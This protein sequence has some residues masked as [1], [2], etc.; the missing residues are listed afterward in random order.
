MKILMVCLGNICRSPI[1]EG[2]LRQI[3][4]DADLPLSV[5]S[6]G[7]ERYH[8][9][10]APDKRAINVCKS[11]GVD[12]SGLRQRL[13]KTEDFDRFDR[14]YVMDANNYNDVKRMARTPE[15]MEKVEFLLDVVYPNA[16]KPVPDPYYGDSFDFE[17][18]FHLIDVACRAIVKSLIVK[19]TSTK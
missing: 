9:G 1:A 2:V 14:I 13:F 3:A 8:L 10:D 6:C 12:I 7:F 15:D 5:D 17:N 4:L 11:H 16:N 18:A 19:Q